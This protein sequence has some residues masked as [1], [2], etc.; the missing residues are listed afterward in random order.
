[1]KGDYIAHCLAI[2]IKVLKNTYQYTFV[3]NFTKVYW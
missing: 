1:M 2:I 3:F